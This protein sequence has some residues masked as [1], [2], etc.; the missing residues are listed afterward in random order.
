MDKKALINSGKTTVP[1]NDRTGKNFIAQLKI[2]LQ[3]FKS[4]PDT[5]I[6]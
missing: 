1:L 6:A 2:N 5:E 3:R 4:I